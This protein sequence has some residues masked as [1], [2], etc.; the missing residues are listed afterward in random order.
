MILSLIF[1]LVKFSEISPKSIFNFFEQ[2]KQKKC[3]HL[4]LFFTNFIDLVDIEP[5][6]ILNKPAEF[7]AD[8]ISILKILNSI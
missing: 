7:M 3:T 6:L 2:A 5:D 1:Y 8:V 4:S